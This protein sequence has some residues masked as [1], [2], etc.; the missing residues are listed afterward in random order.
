MTGNTDALALAVRRNKGRG[1]ADAFREQVAGALGREPGSL[2]V[3]GLEEHDRAAVVFGDARTRAAAEC[4]APGRHC[5]NTTDPGEVAPFLAS[6]RPGFPSAEMLLFREDGKYCGA[7]HVTSAELFERFFSLFEVDGEDLLACTPDG[8]AGLFAAAW[9][10]PGRR[11]G[12][13]VVYAV[14]AWYPAGEP[15]RNDEA[16]R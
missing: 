8:A 3:T 2:R 16:A 6:I 14:Q 9:E 4:G 5:L 12:P 7:V 1:L 10:E 11:P 15:A 13:R